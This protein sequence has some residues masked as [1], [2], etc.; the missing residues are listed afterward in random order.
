MPL[1]S[2]PRSRPPSDRIRRV[3]GDRA[4][5]GGLE[6]GWEQVS[7]L[8]SHLTCDAGSL[9]RI[10]LTVKSRHGGDSQP[11]QMRGLA[12]RP[13]PGTPPARLPAGGGVGGR[14]AVPNRCGSGDPQRRSRAT[15]APGAPHWW[16]RRITTHAA[17]PVVL[18]W[19]RSRGMVALSLLLLAAGR[20]AAWCSETRASRR[21]KL[22]AAGHGRTAALLYLA[23]RAG[24]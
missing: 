9:K 4:L 12:L 7:R 6:G 3:A 1:L 8:T 21:T 13:A 22:A 5:D 10:S 23:T 18:A 19:I 15:Q 2:R 11:M 16:A 14:P 24:D 20:R 17:D